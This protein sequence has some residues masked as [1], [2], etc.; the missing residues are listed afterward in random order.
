MI[1]RVEQAAALCQEVNHP[2]VKIL[3]DTYHMSVEGEPLENIAKYTNLIKHVHIANPVH[4]LHPTAD[5][6]YDY[7]QVVSVLK[8]A[9]YR[10]RV[11]VEALTKNDFISEAKASIPFVCDTLK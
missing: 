1:N 4:R 9:N 7:T 3:A 2:F 10:G 11:T 5:D 8:Q 6:G